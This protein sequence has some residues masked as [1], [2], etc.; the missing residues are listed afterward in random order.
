MLFI[1]SYN[2]Q[3]FLVAYGVSSALSLAVWRLFAHVECK[4]DTV[5]IPSV[6]LLFGAKLRQFLRMLSS[7]QEALKSG[8]RRRPVLKGRLESG[9]RSITT[10]LAETVPASGR[11]YPHKKA[12]PTRV[13]EPA[14]N[15][16]EAGRLQPS[17]T[18]DHWLSIR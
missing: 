15:V 11:T 14:C 10:A 2:G 13:S 9:E 17:D 6:R 5:R 1:W 4:T 16:V 18:L 12:C 7:G 3:P 8:C